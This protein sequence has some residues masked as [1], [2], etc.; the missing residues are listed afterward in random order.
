M[1]VEYEQLI[2]CCCVRDIEGLKELDYPTFTYE[3][4]KCD[5]VHL[6]TVDDSEG[7]TKFTTT[8]MKARSFLEK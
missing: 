4:Q 6:I 5:T 1:K 7:K 2:E 3:C 8:E